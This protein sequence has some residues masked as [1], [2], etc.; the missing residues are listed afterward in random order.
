MCEGYAR[1]VRRRLGEEARRQHL[2][3]LETGAPVRAAWPGPSLGYDGLVDPV[4]V[5]PGHVA[6]QAQ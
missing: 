3:R 1:R 5:P 2:V 6:E 4:A